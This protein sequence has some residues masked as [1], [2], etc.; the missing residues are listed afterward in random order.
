MPECKWCRRSI[1]TVGSLGSLRSKRSIA[2]RFAGPRAAM[3]LLLLALGLASGLLVSAQGVIAS[4]PIEDV[5]CLAVDPQANRIYVATDTGVTVLDGQTNTVLQQFP[6]DGGTRAVAVNP[7][8]NRLYVAGGAV[9]DLLVLNATT[10]AQL[11]VI[12]ELIFEC[13]SIAVDPVRNRIW[14]DDRSTILSVPDRVVVYDGATNTVVGRA[15]LGSSSTIIEQI[16]VAVDPVLNRGY[17]TY[18]GDDTLSIID[19]AS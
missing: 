4:V 10:G 3:L 13:G 15:D 9:R 2:R 18:T 5:R 6:I 16:R 14:I 19:G 17:A 7:Q 8:T 1:G 12:D 11:A